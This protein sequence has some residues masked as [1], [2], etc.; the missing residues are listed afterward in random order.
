MHLLA[1]VPERVGRGDARY[2]KDCFDGVNPLNINGEE[3]DVFAAMGRALVFLPHIKGAEFQA[4]AEAMALIR[5]Q[6]GIDRNKLEVQGLAR[7]AQEMGI[8][9]SFDE[10]LQRQMKPRKYPVMNCEFADGDPPTYRNV[11]F[12]ILEA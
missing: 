9:I 5:K 2:R 3:I 4:D 12:R 7:K 11:P 1:T 8:E 10:L 6:A